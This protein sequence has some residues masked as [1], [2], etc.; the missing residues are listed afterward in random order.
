MIEIPQ[1]TDSSKKK[2]TTI[3][4]DLSQVVLSRLKEVAE[5]NGRTM[6]AELR[7]AIKRN[8]QNP[9]TLANEEADDHTPDLVADMFRNRFFMDVLWP[10]WNR[11]E[12]HLLEDF[13]A[14]QRYFASRYGVP[15]DV[16]CGM[17]MDILLGLAFGL[18]AGTP[19]KAGN[20]DSVIR[21]SQTL[22]TQ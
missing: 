22:P 2:S 8:C 18:E 14:H 15:H 7:F 6:S 17:A 4:L 5:Q 20:C 16:F 1:E 13:N 9:I 19:G 11:H 21:I 12:N 3:T 10:G